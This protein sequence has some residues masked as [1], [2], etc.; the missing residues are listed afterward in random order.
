[1]RY[2][3]NREQEIEERDP[4]TLRSEIEEAEHTIRDLLRQI[5]REQA[6]IAEVA[7][8]YQQ[9]VAS[10]VEVSRAQAAL[11]V[12]RDLWRQRAEQSEHTGAELHLVPA[13][14]NAIRKAI[15]RLHHPD[16][17]GDPERMKLWNAVLD[18]LEQ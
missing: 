18:Q 2:F 10:L 3:P 9:V 17:G 4:A 6:K 7:K 12:D 8:S 11:E 16:T 13:E 14:A 5:S 15:A 1:M